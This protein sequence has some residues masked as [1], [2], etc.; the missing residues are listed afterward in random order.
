MKND[1]LQIAAASRAACNAYN[2][3]H[4]HFW[5]GLGG[6]CGLASHFLFSNLEE[7]GFSPTF[8][9]AQAKIDALFGQRWISVG[10]LHVDITATQF[11][12]RLSPVFSYKG[13]PD[14][15]PV[16]LKYFRTKGTRFPQDFTIETATNQ[17]EID[18][19]M[20]LWHT[21]VSYCGMTRKRLNHYYAHGE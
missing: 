15:H 1:I 5:S 7:E 12:H 4:G 16:L 13:T 10:K 20:K 2:E 8:Y 21:T 14:V 19:L 17:K 6:M 3:A 11:N 9:I 18:K